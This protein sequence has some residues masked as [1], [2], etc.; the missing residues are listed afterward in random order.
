MRRQQHKPKRKKHY[1]KPK[2]EWKSSKLIEALKQQYKFVIGIDEVGV[3][4]ICG[5]ITVAAV[6]LPSNLESKKIKDS[7]KFSSK[8][9]RELAYEFVQKH[10]LFTWV[11]NTPDTWDS[12][13]VNPGI[14]LE[15]LM[16]KTILAVQ[17]IYPN[18][19]VIIID[20][21]RTLDPDNFPGIT[22]PQVAIP[23]A[24]KLV[25]AVSAASI[26]AK[27]ERDRT[28]EALAKVVDPA[29]GWDRNSGYQTREHE[30][31]MRQHGIT[32]YHRKHISSV[33][34]FDKNYGKDPE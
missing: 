5:P 28:M 26:V 32:P 33:R 6:V 10:S 22:I 14:L 19:S 16:Y 3:G 15:E 29:Y 25:Q 34:G 27:V 9:Q 23:S 11:E 7:K 1:M 18:E 21:V 31:A 2:V 20:G 24:D 30:A 13:A 17:R 8:H 4:A 12:P